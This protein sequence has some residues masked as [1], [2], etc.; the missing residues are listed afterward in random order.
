M[1]IR[2]RFLQSERMKGYQE[3]L[4]RYENMPFYPNNGQS[5]GRFTTTTI[6]RVQDAVS[7]QIGKCGRQIT[8]QYPNVPRIKPLKA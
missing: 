2:T 8:L 1:L 5:V 4:Y 3:K 7:E 6:V